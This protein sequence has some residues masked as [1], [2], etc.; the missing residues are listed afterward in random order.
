MICFLLLFIDR[1][2][3]VSVNKMLKANEYLLGFA[4]EH[5]HILKKMTMDLSL[6]DLWEIH[7]WQD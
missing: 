3:R 2:L 4:N 5:F 7:I 6:E 1:L